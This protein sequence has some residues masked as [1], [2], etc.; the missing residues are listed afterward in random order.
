MGLILA[1]V[2]VLAIVGIA[3]FGTGLGLTFVFGVA[4]PYLA[5]AI[6]VFGVIYRIINW[7]KVPVPFR[8]PTTC[9]QEKSLDFIKT[10]PIDNPTSKFAVIVRMFLE[11]TVFRSL[12]R[13]SKAELTEDGRI[14]YQWEKWLWIFALLFHWGMFFVLVRHMRFFTAEVPSGVRV[15][16]KIDGV[17]LIDLH[18]V[19]LTGFFMLLGLTGLLLRRLMIPKV[20]YISL[21]NDYFPLFLLL[22]I[23]C[24][25]MLMRYLTR[26][27][28]TNIRELMLSLLTFSPQVPEAG[29]IAPIFYVHLTLV[30]VLLMYFPASK[31]MHA[32]GIFMSP[33]RNMVNNSRAVHH[34][35]PWNYPVE[36]HTYEE[37]EDEYREK[38]AMVGLP[39]DKS[40]EQAQ[41]DAEKGIHAKHGVM[42]DV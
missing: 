39:L 4:L 36:V 32:F 5:I 40:V 31:L 17:M 15:L 14:V 10:N 3:Y 1:L 33:T 8:I 30:S 24:S 22:G 18:P 26:V 28:V 38:M 41:A 27:D 42:S 37:Y 9:G 11:V 21:L 12:F 6:F 7:A 2:V 29:A 35:N 23:A 20:R 16:E 19:Y 25:G 34:E 13:N